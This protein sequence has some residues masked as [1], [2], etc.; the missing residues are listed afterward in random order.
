MRLVQAT[1]HW[2]SRQDET[3][4]NLTGILKTTGT[5]TDL[6]MFKRIP[7]PRPREA[8]DGMEIKGEQSFR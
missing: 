6:K 1:L 8:T 5:T 7:G 3:R 4:K 2:R